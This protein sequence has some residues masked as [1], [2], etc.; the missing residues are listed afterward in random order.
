[1]SHPVS[2]T[3]PHVVYVTCMLRMPC[4]HACLFLGTCIHTLKAESSRNLDPSLIRVH[5]EISDVFQISGLQ[6]PRFLERNRLK[7]HLTQT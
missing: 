5:P 4:M 7:A 3:S 2:V 6:S 1:M